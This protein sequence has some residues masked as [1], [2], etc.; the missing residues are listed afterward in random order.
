MPETTIE[1]RA[2]MGL[3]DTFRERGWSNPRQLAISGPTKGFDLLAQLD[4][5]VERVEGIFIN[6]RVFLPPVAVVSPGDR[7]ALAPPGIPGPYRVLLGF[8]RKLPVDGENSDA[9]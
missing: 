5:P 9:N 3:A 2:F 7:V 1:L 6:G 4:I 8:K